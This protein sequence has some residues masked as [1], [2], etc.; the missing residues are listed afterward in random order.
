M[1]F[2]TT[3]TFLIVI[4]PSTF[5][6]ENK[7]VLLVLKGSVLEFTTFRKIGEIHFLCFILSESR[8]R[9][10]RI[11]S[12]MRALIGIL[13]LLLLL[14]TSCFFPALGDVAGLVR[15]YWTGRT[16]PCS[17]EPLASSALW[18]AE[19]FLQ[20]WSPAFSGDRNSELSVR[21][22]SKSLCAW[23]SAAGRPKVSVY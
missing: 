8:W 10:A 16:S 17:T 18:D 9:N 23:D 15:C 4:I 21:R 22:C 6:E 5:T 13:C 11:S 1:T 3:L 14:C 2:R 20:F 7:M 19:S 12:G